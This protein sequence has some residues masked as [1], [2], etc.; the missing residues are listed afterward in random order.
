MWESVLRC[1]QYVPHG[2]L[3]RG[4]VGGVVFGGLTRATWGESS[5]NSDNEAF[6]GG[7][8]LR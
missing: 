4:L 3:Y 8:L 5:R 2:E 7:E 1:C 6:A